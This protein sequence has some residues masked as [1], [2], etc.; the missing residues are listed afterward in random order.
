MNTETSY[1]VYIIC[2]HEKISDRIQMQLDVPYHTANTRISYLFYSSHSSFCAVEL[3]CLIFSVDIAVMH[4]TVRRI[5][6]HF[7]DGSGLELIPTTTS[8]V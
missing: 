4:H 7:S 1:S 6:V 8:L 2:V 3:L 5:D